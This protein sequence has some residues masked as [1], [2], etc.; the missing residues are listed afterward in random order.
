M[1]QLCDKAGHKNREPVKTLRPRPTGTARCELLNLNS[2]NQLVPRPALNLTPAF[3]E[4][5]TEVD[6]L[7]SADNF[8][9]PP[10][11]KV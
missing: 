7:A 1:L 5:V 9:V 11:V 2:E 3:S 8:R 6:G 10:S 4:I